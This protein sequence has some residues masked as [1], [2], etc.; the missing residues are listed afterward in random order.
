M[1]VLVLKMDT[2]LSSTIQTGMN[3]GHK[4]FQKN[5][6]TSEKIVTFAKNYWHI[7]SG[8]NASYGATSVNIELFSI[9]IR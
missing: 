6:R 4:G 3:K 1:C 9:F 5:N 2:K 7:K 8:K